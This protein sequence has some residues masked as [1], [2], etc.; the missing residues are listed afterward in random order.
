MS[1][2]EFEFDAYHVVEA[3]ATLINVVVAAATA[4]ELTAGSLFGDADCG[5]DRCHVSCSATTSRM[6]QRMSAARRTGRRQEKLSSDRAATRLRHSVESFG[7][8]S[9]STKWASS[10]APMTGSPGRPAPGR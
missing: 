1:V 8:M 4:I 10:V 3:R 6:G 2:E 5:A 9:F 7:V